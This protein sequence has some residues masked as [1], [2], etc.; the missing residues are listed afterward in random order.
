MRRDPLLTQVIV[1]LFT[2]SFFSLAFVGL[3]PVIADLN[4]GIDPKSTAYGVLYAC[5]GLGAALGAI[6]VGTVFAHRSKAKLLRPGFVAF[7]IVLERVR[8]LARGGGR[9]SGERGARVRLLRRHHVAVDRAAGGPRGEHAGRVMALW[10]MGFGGTVP[11]GVLVAGWVENVTSITRWCWPARSGRSCSRSGRIPC[12]HPAQEGS[13]RCL[14]VKPTPTANCDC[15]R[16]TSY[17]QPI[18]DAMDAIA[19]ATPE[20]RVRDL[21]AHLVGVTAD[22]T[23]G[24]LE[25]VATDPWTAAQVDARRD[26]SITEILAE[27]DDYGPQFEGA[28]V[29]LPH[30][31]GGQAVFDAVTHEA[32]MRHALARPGERTCDGV[33]ISFEF[34]C[35]GRTAGSLPALRI[36]TERGETIAGTGDPIAT[37][38]TSQFEFIR[39]V[40]RATE[41]GGDRRLRVARSDGSRGPARCAVLQDAPGSARTSEGRRRSV[42]SEQIHAHDR[43]GP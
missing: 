8:G 15:G 32:D 34:C 31:I 13:H 25:G 16:P 19:P 39:A 21:L 33:A 37:L 5:F 23:N 2:F 40:V 6:T 9:V 18:P 29:A 35:L 38:T 41:R 43:R 11:L 10:I 7:A 42:N 30:A 28:L 14:N 3:M 1:T 26:A 36:V 27:W 24:R 20:W 17:A 22:A 12:E 4:L